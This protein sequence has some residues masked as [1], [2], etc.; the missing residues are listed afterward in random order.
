MVYVAGIM[1]DS[2]KERSKIIV[3]TKPQDR[4][5]PRP[6]LYMTNGTISKNNPNN[7]NNNLNNPPVKRARDEGN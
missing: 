6:H 7:P 5:H 1:S 3:S 2:E 4:I